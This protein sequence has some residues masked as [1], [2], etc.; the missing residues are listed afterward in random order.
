MLDS[1]VR[2]GGRA[3]EVGKGVFIE[4]VLNGRPSTALSGRTIFSYIMPYE[5]IQ[6]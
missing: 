3:A 6:N 1:N 4:D 5:E 2:K